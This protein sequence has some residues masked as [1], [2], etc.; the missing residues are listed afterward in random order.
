MTARHSLCAW[1]PYPL[2]CVPGQRFRIEQWKPHLEAEGISVDLR[3]FADAGLLRVLHQR[4]HLPAK[5]F[6][7]L[8]AFAGRARDAVDLR[9]YDAVLVH[10]A[11]ALAG[12]ALIERLAA[13]TRPLIFDFDDAIYRL[14][15][16]DANRW[17]SRLKFP[18]KTATLCR[19]SRHVV[20]GNDYLGEYARR[21]NAN[22]TVIPSSIDTDSYRPRT[23]SSRDGRLLMGW[24]GSSTSQTYLEMFAP[25]LKRVL[26]G[27]PLELLVVSDREPVLPGVP[28]RWRAWSRERET[29]DLEEFDIGIMPMPDDEWARGKCSM[30]AL[31]YMGMGVPAVCSA[32]GANKEVVE[33]GRN[34]FLAETPDDWRTAIET[35]IRD[36][37]LRQ[38]MGEAGRRTVEARYSM[39]ASAALFADVVRATVGRREAYPGKRESLH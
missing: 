5:S 23:R 22:V 3:P 12:P 13:R 6:G 16:S 38:R 4:G 21:F 34:G 24:M 10:R 15:S 35:L 39:R 2:D 27:Q 14:H 30:K 9:G 37:A 8:K 36:P 19:V 1:V 32:V 7:M 17:T 18:G 11:A 25:V 29:A 26:D 20:A 31:Q 28:H 33:H